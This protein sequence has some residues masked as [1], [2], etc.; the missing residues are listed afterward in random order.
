VCARFSKAASSVT[1]GHAIGPFWAAGDRPEQH[2]SLPN[3]L[4]ILSNTLGLR[5]K[6]QQN[7]A[8][9]GHPAEEPGQTGGLPEPLSDRPLRGRAVLWREELPDQ[10]DPWPKE[11]HGSWGGVSWRRR[12]GW[13]VCGRA[14]VVG[15]C[16]LVCF[17][18]TRRMFGGKGERKDPT[19]TLENR[20]KQNQHKLLPSLLFFSV[21][22]SQVE[23]NEWAKDCYLKTVVLLRR[24]WWFKDV[25]QESLMLNCKY[26][27][28]YT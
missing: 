22:E 21:R 6:P 7:A 3:L 8:R 23:L 26:K 11:A 13:L 10:A 2:L 20:R 4:F 14:G 12:E 28:Y 25:Q 27:C 15:A 1:I 5:R 19:Y 17:A 18:C 9:A 16:R 24:W